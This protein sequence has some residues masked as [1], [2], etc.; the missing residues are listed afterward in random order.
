MRNRVDPFGDLHDVADRGLFT[1]NR[2]CLVDAHRRL[3]RHHRG[4][5]WITC[6]LRYR[7]WRSPLSQPRHWTPLFFLDDAVA[8]AAGHRP[9]GLCRRSD[10]ESYRDAVMRGTGSKTSPTAADLNARL[11]TERLGHG[12]GL[13]RGSDRKTWESPIGSLPDGTVIVGS[14]LRG[15]QLLFGGR[16]ST[17]VFSGWA[18]ASPRPQRGSVTVLTPP[19]SVVALANGFVPTVHPTATQGQV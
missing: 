5:R 8:L 15:P 7:D 16:V 18:D 12:R 13:N 14:D 6:V 10:Y 9:C 17:F 19:T 3:A 1:G 11:A 4:T 2:G